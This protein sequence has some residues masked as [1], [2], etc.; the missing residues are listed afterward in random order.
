MKGKGDVNVYVLDYLPHIRRQLVHQSSSV[1]SPT[2]VAQLPMIP[3][4]RL[5][6]IRMEA[7]DENLNDKQEDIGKSPKDNSKM[8]IQGENLKQPLKHL[9]D[10]PPKIK[11][12][13]SKSPVSRL[14]SNSPI[15]RSES[16]TNSARKMKA[17]R[18]IASGDQ[19]FTKDFMKLPDDFED[20]IDQVNEA[21]STEEDFGNGSKLSKILNRFFRVR[22]PKKQAEKEFFMRKIF[23]R[24][25]M[26]IK[27]SMTAMVVHSMFNEG[28]YWFESGIIYAPEDTAFRVSYILLVGLTYLLLVTNNSRN[29]HN[30][31]RALILVIILGGTLIKMIEIQ[32]L[33]IFTSRATQELYARLTQNRFE[34]SGFVL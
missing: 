34:A 18:S 13:E 23:G 11:N 7:I 21:F 19:S 17:I 27:F 25:R 10:S 33:V 6:A 8:I 30:Y 20:S 32:Y 16:I 12:A 14:R 3:S 26:A 4:S 1:A 28:S 9:K 29:S 2:G 15:R 24:Y 5:D 31:F 22:N